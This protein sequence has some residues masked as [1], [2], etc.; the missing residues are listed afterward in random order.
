MKEFVF[1][2]CYD[3]EYKEMGDGCLRSIKRFYPDAD[4][5][6]FESPRQGD[7]FELQ[8]FCDFGLETGKKLFDKYKR[9]IYVDSDHI[10]CNK[11]PDLFGDFDMGVVQNN[12]PMEDIFGKLNAWPYINAGLQISTNKDAWQEF[13]DEHYKRSVNRWEALITQL[14]LTYCY[15]KSKFKYKLLE[16]PDRTYGISSFDGYP[17]LKVVDNELY[18][19]TEDTQTHIVSTKKVCMLHFAGNVFKYRSQMLWEKFKNED[20]IKLIKSYTL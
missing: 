10:M 1:F 2:S 6:H 4:V 3:Q 11:C 12:I 16:F 19:T 7:S 5:L 20:A 8:K 15:H 14:A 13:M 17:F 9:I 18:V